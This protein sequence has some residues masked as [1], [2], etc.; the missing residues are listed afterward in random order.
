MRA[1]ACLVG[2]FLS[3]ILA[4]VAPAHAVGIEFACIT[5]NRAGDCAIGEAQLSVELSDLG[6]GAVRFDFFNSGPESSVIS[7]IYFDDGRL[8]ALATIHDGSGV[9]FVSGASPPNLPGGRSLAAPFRTTAAFSSEA[10][11]P[12]AG[13]GIGPGETL[14]LEFTLQPGQT[15]DD[16]LRTLFSGDLRIGIHAIAYDSHGGESF[17]NHPVIPEPDTAALL[18]VGLLGLR[19]LRRR[20]RSA[21]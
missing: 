20:T 11:P 7:E 10:T 6:A 4:M 12:P 18:G 19:A 5:G 13:S 1:S 17:V 2:T 14:G 15:F 16:V 9:S 3:A 8:L 21:R